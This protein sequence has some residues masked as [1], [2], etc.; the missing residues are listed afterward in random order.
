MSLQ[1]AAVIGSLMAAVSG[2]TSAAAQVPALPDTVDRFIRAELARQRIPG[3][4]V[5]VVRGDRV[6]L[7]RGYGFADLDRKVPATEHL[8][9]RRPRELLEGH[10]RGDR[11]AG[12]AEQRGVPE[13]A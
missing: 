9:D 12:E 13:T 3:M 6:L 2:L 1:P 10:R 11:V 5:A 8:Q 7:A 4:S